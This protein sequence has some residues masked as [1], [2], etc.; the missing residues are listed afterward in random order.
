MLD[1]SIDWFRLLGGD[2]V[3]I[4]PSAS[5]LIESREHPGLRLH[6]PAMLAGNMAAVLDAL[7]GESRE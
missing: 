2:F 5:G 1:S 6:G 4:Q 7:K 3:R